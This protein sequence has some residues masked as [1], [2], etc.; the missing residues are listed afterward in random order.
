VANAIVVRYRTKPEAADKNAQLV[1]AVYEELAAR[2]PEGF[3]CMTLQ[4]DDGV[5][6]VHVAVHEEGAENPLSNSDAF[7]HFQAELPDRLDDGP[8]PSPAVVVGSY[9]FGTGV[10]AT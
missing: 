8:E 6:F 5:S 2:E 9:G 10:S 4:L 1:R 7:A 3:H